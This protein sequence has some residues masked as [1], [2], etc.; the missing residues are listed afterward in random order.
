M[1]ATTD[2]RA[3]LTLT[4]ERRLAAPREL[5]FQAWT[6]PR[7]LR[8]WSAP[9]GFEIPEADGELR[10]GGTW[11]TTM[12]A[13]GGAEHRLIGTY[14]EIVPPKRLVF[15][16]AWLDDAGR[17]GLETLVTIELDEIPGGTLLRFAQTGFAS[18]GTRDGH[19]LGWGEA[20]DRLAAHL[21]A[22]PG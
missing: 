16:H 1:D 14:R 19:G 20:L 9:H 3:G 18:E 13:P 15:T 4:L 2:L 17:P 5:V 11:R 21:A 12:R 10:P 7:H 22:L 6:E 8:R